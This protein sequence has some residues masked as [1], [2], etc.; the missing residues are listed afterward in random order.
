MLIFD[1]ETD[2]LLDTVTK[3]HCG[4][5]YNTATEEYKLY[6]PQEI[7]N[8]LEELLNADSIC[9]HNVI[10]FDI[11]VLEKLYNVQFDQ[12]KVIDT[13]VLARLVY[14]NISDIDAVLVRQNKLSRKLWGSHSL[15]AYGQRLGVLKGTYAEDTEDCWACFNEDMLVYNKQDV[16]VTKK[17]YENLLSKGFTEDASLLEH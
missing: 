6:R 13:L 5:I 8:M 14:S 2:G 7:E 1:I 15:K 11:P 16:V 17:L 12:E 4:C 3:V 10:M 9:G